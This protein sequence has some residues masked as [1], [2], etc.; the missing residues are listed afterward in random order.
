MGAKV[1]TLTTANW[2]SDPSTKAIVLMEYFLASQR[3]QTAFYTGQITSLPGLIQ[4]H[5]QDPQRLSERTRDRLQDYLS[6]YFDE[7]VVNAD[8]T[9]LD[10][11]NGQFNI[12][13]DVT[14]VQDGS[15]YSLGRLIEVGDSKVLQVQDVD[16]LPDTVS[17]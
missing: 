2:V 11:I 9:H 6:R 10:A 14:V 4:R 8:A 7:V 15:A 5:G 1:P 12:R 13:L 17:R 3:S 16:E